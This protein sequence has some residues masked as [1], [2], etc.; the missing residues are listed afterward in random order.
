MANQLIKIEKGPVDDALMHRVLVQWYQ[1][2]RS[3]TMRVLE[4]TVAGCFITSTLWFMYLRLDRFAWISIAGLILSTIVLYGYVPLLAKVALKA[5]K[6]APSYRAVKHY[7]FTPTSF[8]FSYGDVA[9]VEGALSAFAEARLTHDAL[10]FLGKGGR[11]A[12]WLERAEMSSDTLETL[13]SW[14]KEQGVRV[15]GE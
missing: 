6:L 2:S 10:L 11:L 8:R 3:K 1:S 13:L 5:S 9:P 12:L 4:K 14:L 7:E 15:S